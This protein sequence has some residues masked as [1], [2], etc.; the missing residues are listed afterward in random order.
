MKVSEGD[1][2]RAGRTSAILPDPVAEARRLVD[3][4]STEGLPLR[5]VGGVAVWIRAPSLRDAD[6]PRVFHDIDLV[7]WRRTSPELAAL[8]EAEGYEPHRRFN[9]LAGD[10]LLFFDEPN[11]RRIDVFLDRLE[12]CHTLEFAD[13][14]TTDP[15]TLPLADLLLSKLQIVKLSERDVVDVAALL[16]D[17]AVTD[18]GSGIELGRL[19]SVCA[20]DWGWWRTVTGNLA[21]ME[22]AWAGAAPGPGPDLAVARERAAGLRR[23]LEG[24]PK[25]LRWKVRARVGERVSWYQEPEEVR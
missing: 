24:A 8:L 6:P 7:G 4:A 10:R 13:R 9:T 25:S 14:L 23:A 18:G 17:H 16:S 1:P 22:S 11:R 19:V 15:D 5:A 20:N 2:S 21:T 3:R 12:M